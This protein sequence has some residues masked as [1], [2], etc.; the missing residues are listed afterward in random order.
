MLQRLFSQRSEFLR[1]SL[2]KSQ[3]LWEAAFVAGGVLAIGLTLHLY[4]AFEASL[5]TRPQYGAAEADRQI[6][7]AKSY[8]T[9]HPDDMNTY[10]ALA[11]AYYQKGPEHYV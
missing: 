2:P 11:M 8:L 9:S 10:A 4:P 5:I 3:L 6:D 7:S 1:I